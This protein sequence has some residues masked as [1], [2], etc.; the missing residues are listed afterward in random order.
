MVCTAPAV[1]AAAAAEREHHRMTA[2]DD[3]DTRAFAAGGLRS[4]H[5]SAQNSICWEGV[6][7]LLDHAA[8]AE[9]CSL[10]EQTR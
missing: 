7:T 4:L 9:C 2:A 6:H 1:A 8:A 3:L 5:A 10:L